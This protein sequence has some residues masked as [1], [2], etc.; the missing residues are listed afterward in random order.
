VHGI[1]RR[2]AWWDAIWDIW[3]G[4]CPRICQRSVV[5]EKRYR[6]SG[7]YAVIISDLAVFKI[8]SNKK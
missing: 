6:G 5:F 3:M 1:Q 8:S 7:G 4:I 2:H